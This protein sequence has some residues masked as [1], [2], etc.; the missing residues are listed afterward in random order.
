MNRRVELTVAQAAA[1][2]G[3]S[4]NAIRLLLSR[5]RGGLT[6]T[7]RGLVDAEQLLDWLDRRGSH[8]Q[9]AASRVRHQYLACPVAGAGVAPRS[10]PV[11]HSRPERSARDQHAGGD[12]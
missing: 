7:R 8:G 10:H 3:L 9:H 12:P 4:A 1:A 6:R 2:T 11:T 5:R